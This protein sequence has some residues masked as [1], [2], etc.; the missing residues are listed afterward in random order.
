[1]KCPECNTIVEKRDLAMSELRCL[2][3]LYCPAC[4]IDIIV[5]YHDETEQVR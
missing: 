1:L 3:I 5:K 4:D 2:Y